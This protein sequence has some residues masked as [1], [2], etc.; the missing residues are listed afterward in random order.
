[1]TYVIDENTSGFFILHDGRVI[2]TTWDYDHAE[3]ADRLYGCSVLELVDAGSVRITFLEGFTIQLP[4][5]MSD[6]TRRSLKAVVDQVQ[7]EYGLPYVVHFDDT[8]G[9]EMPVSRPMASISSL[10]RQK[11]YPSPLTMEGP[12]P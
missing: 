10:P 3:T 5:F 8:R 11:V 6:L 1:M 12:S 4:P 2:T 9:A 7:D